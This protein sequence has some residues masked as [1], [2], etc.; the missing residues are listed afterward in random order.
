MTFDPDRFLGASPPPFKWVPF[1]GGVHR[2]PGASFANMEMD[3]ALRTLL[4]EFRFAPT[5]APG[6]RRVN[7]GVAGFRSGGRGSARAVV[8]R[9]VPTK[10]IDVWEP[11]DRTT[12]VSVADAHSSVLTQRDWRRPAR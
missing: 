2:C 6:E 8:C 9:R 10:A 7:R 4:R 12:T 5:D 3:V 11:L 1:G